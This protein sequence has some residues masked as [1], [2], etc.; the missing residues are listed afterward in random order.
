MVGYKSSLTPLKNELKSI[1]AC[2]IAEAGFYQGRTARWGISWT[3]QSDIKLDDFMPNKEFQKKKLKPPVSFCVP[4]SYDSTT[5][6]AKL[7]E[8][9]IDLKVI[10]GFILF[11]SFK[12]K[13]IFLKLVD[14]I[15]VQISKR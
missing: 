12:L 4:E 5:A 2:A 9:L 7:K 14:Y 11:L 6:L 3:F 13:S 1:G 8:L 10:F 15:C